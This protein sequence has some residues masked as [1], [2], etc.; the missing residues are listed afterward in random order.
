MDI[1][2]QPGIGCIMH[3]SIKIIYNDLIQQH[4]ERKHPRKLRCFNN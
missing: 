1:T 4:L 3:A 2:I